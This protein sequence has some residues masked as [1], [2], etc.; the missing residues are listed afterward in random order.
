MTAARTKSLERIEQRMEDMDKNSLRY[1]TLQSAKNFK[2]SWIE[3]AQ[4]LYS[5]WKDKIY[6]KWGYNTFDAYTSKEIGIKKQTAMKL[7]KSYYFLEKE[8][9][10]YLKE[11]Y[12]ESPDVATVPTYDAVNI[13]RLAKSKKTLDSDDYNTLK[14]K[15]FQKGRDAS[16]IK[17]DLTALI[18]ERQELEP[19]E[20]R[21]KREIASVKRFLSTL[22]SLKRDIELLKI[23]PASVIKETDNLIK[24]IEA[25]I[26]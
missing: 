20:A 11:E 9:P 19:E 8:E 14:E 2:T 15:V 16:E 6:K 26:V 3:F 24:K 13:L 4:A 10:A 22:K 7:L 25:E 1:R 21:R 18:K 17:K 12:A 5:V 23:L